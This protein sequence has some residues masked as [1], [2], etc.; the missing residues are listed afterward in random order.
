MKA[1]ARIVV[2]AGCLG[3]LSLPLAAQEVIHALTG[4]VAAINSNNNAKTITVL[5]DSGAKA[6]FKEM[7][8]ANTS[9]EFDKKIAAGTTNAIAF[10]K[11][12][13]YAIVFYY[14]DPDRT[15]VAL[16][17][18][19]PGP[20]TSTDGAVKKFEGRAHS[21]S[22]ADKTGTLQTFKIN[23]STVAETDFGVVEGLKFEAR[24]GD[25]V[26][27]VSATVDGTL[28]ALFVRDK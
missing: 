10:S 21:I 1:L 9:I 26:R 23:A 11:S 25:Q 13:A 19:G 15:V 24:E 2:H 3:F 16:K 12:G 4:T 5:Q 27:V 28:T 22:V 17:D 14:G 20:F 7:S 6:E 18:L 8:K